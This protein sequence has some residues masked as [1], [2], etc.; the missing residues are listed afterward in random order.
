MALALALS[1]WAYFH[2]SANPEITA[3]F[4]QQL[5]VPITV[6]G[7]RAGNISRFA[8]KEALVTIVAPRNGP[9]IKPDEV[10]AV[11]NLGEKS[12]GV[13]N[14]PI[15][16]IAP[17]LDI[18]SISP[19]SVTLEI[20]KLEERS[21]PIAIDYTG[22][23]RR[24]IVVDGVEVSPRTITVHGTANDLAR[25]SAVRIGVPFVRDPTTYDAMTKPIATDVR[26]SEV[27]NVQ[28]F[29]NAV[30]VRARFVKST[31]ENP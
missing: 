19:A 10:K 3:H 21:V 22:E 28:V 4:D 14:I 5:S 18:R 12:A 25:V 7:L 26:G 9:A 24:G 11:L 30:R 16:I 29:P 2:F 8:E 6:T 17:S 31:T 20:A 13:Y 1:A 15:Q 23:R 27:A